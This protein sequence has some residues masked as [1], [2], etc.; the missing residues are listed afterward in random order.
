MLFAKK[1]CP[2]TFLSLTLNARERT[3]KAEDV[4]HF[5]AQHTTKSNNEY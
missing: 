5:Y 3:T 2:L 4:I 1:L